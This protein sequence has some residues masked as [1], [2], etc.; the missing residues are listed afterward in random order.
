MIEVRLFGSL[1][2]F[3][4]DPSVTVESRAWVAMESGDTVADVLS[5]L[6]LP[7]EEVGHIFVNGRYSYTA[8]RM[9]VRDGARLGVF[10][11]NMSMLYC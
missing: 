2:R 1:R 6:Q 3:A 5:R 4:E 8:L 9:A 10:P 7:R 11:K